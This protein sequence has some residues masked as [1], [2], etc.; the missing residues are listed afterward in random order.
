M[1]TALFDALCETSPTRK[2][3]RVAAMRVEDALS[4]PALTADQQARIPGRPTRPQ[5]VNP[6]DVPHRGLGT[7]EGRAAM[8][9]AVAHI[10]FNA[11]N[12]AL[13][14]ALRFRQMPPDYYADW[15]SVAQDEARH[16]GL[17][18]GRLRDMGWAYG[19]FDAHDG[20]WEAAEKTAHDVL[21][22]MALVPRVLEA[23]GLDVTPNMILR[24][25]E[26]G[27][28]Q[29]AA[30]LRV[31][32]QEEVRH[33]SIGTR[34]FHYLCTQRGLDPVSTFRSLL[35]AHRVR[36]QTPFN[37][38]ARMQAGFD[39]LELSLDSVEAGAKMTPLPARR[40][41]SS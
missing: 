13:D 16:F 37:W 5:R 27:D 21:E 35:S 12:L 7:S 30:V 40:T 11:I 6:R 28:A 9:H 41:V 24:L 14:A 34:W 8:A 23:R 32:L 19:D 25:Q 18:S 26:V 20:L 10:E 2:C 22:R 17:L 3:E 36:L 31:I 33:V 38:D 15:I 1:A 4:A 29:T 39:P